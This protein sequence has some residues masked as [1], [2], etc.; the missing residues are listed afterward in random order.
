MKNKLRLVGAAVAAGVLAVALGSP[1]TS[2][3][4]PTGP[5]PF[6]DLAGVGSGTTQG[7]MD[8]ISD[9]VVSPGGP[10]FPPAGTKLIGSYD[11]DGPPT[12]VTKDP[13]V[14]PG[15][16]MSRPS[17]STAGLQVFD[18]SLNPL[19]PTAGCL[20]FVRSFSGPVAT[21]HPMTWLPFVIDTVDFAVNKLSNLPKQLAR[22][23][24]IAIYTC[25]IP[26]V[27]AY[28][29]PLDSDTSKIFLGFLGIPLFPCVHLTKDG[30]PILEHDGRVL[31]GDANGIVPISIANNIAQGAGTLP[32]IRG[33]SILGAIDINLTDPTNV[34]ANDLPPYEIPTGTADSAPGWPAGP[35]GLQHTYFNVVATAQLS[36][37]EIANVFSGPSPQVCQQLI[38]KQFGFR[39]TC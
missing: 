2:Y 24:L 27:N 33:N 38:I 36:N 4:D 18:A 28:L 21:T 7:V 26:G 20:Q 17:G 31:N 11:A 13:A 35:T 8:A 3:A 19:S 10:G 5:P 23:D 22:N 9:V 25:T 15:C 14:N 39:P 6:R 32:D 16:S 30:V 37:P 12:I 34:P 1:S 29:P